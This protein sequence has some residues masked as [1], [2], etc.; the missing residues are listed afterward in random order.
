[1]SSLALDPFFSKLWW[2][3]NLVVFSKIRSCVLRWQRLGKTKKHWP[4]L[5]NQASNALTHKVDRVLGFF[6]S[7]PNRDPHPLTRRRLCPPSLW[8]LGRD[9]L[10]CGC[11]RGGGGGGSP[12]S[13]EGKTLW[14]SMYTVYAQYFVV[15]Q[16]LLTT[17]D[18][19]VPH[20]KW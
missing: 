19:S 2:L 14:Y 8:F 10:A 5:G 17:E 4:R 13:D 1:M 9:T 3:P 12:N 7:R 6:S 16:I 11:G 20:Q 15:L 18:C